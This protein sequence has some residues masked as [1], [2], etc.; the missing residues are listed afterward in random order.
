MAKGPTKRDNGTEAKDAASA[1][2]SIFK[3]RISNREWNKALKVL[4]T[5]CK[6]TG[7]NIN[8]LSKEEHDTLMNEIVD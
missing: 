3:P 6:K 1:I 5:L 8:D 2:D 4:E 7:K